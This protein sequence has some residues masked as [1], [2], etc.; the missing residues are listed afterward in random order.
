MMS[1]VGAIQCFKQDFKFGGKH[2]SVYST[3]LLRVVSKSRQD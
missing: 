3:P 1:V 2:L